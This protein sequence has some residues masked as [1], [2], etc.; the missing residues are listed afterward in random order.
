M[1]ATNTNPEDAKK[2]RRPSVVTKDL[3]AKYP[4][5]T[6]ESQTILQPSVLSPLETPTTGLLNLE[7]TVIEMISP[8]I[9]VQD[10]EGATSKS[11]HKDR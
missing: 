4:P 6:G 11:D 3:Q 1:F 7:P 2:S 10:L 5:P 9:R 8:T